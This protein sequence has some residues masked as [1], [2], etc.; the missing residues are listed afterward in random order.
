MVDVKSDWRERG[1][2][3][4][5]FLQTLELKKLL[6]LAAYKNERDKLFCSL[7]NVKE[8]ECEA[9]I[10]V[11]ADNAFNRLNRKVAPHNISR[12]CPSLYQYLYNGYKA[13]A[14]L[15]LGDGT[16][17]LSE[18]GVTQGDNLAMAK[19]AIGKICDWH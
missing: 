5:F 14:K 2:T 4:A 18:E 6:Y 16:H 12:S 15:H 1:Y 10:L 8:K 19:Y 7:L 9:V 13:A 3:R 17:I 11:D